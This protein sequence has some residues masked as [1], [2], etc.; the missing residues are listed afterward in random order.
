MPII[1]ICHI[2]RNKT[3]GA[4]SK[5]YLPV[6]AQTSSLI[7]EVP[8]KLKQT[9]ILLLAL[10][11]SAPVHADSEP[12]V[13]PIQSGNETVRYVR[14]VP[15]LEL[16]QSKGIVRVTPLPMDHGSLSFTVAVYNN[17]ENPANFGIENVSP[18]F[19]SRLVTVFTKD[20]LVRRAKN[21]AFWSQFGL[22]LVGG[23]AAGL[24]ASQQDVYSSRWITPRG[25]YQNIFTAPSV[26][27]QWQAMEITDVTV[28]GM[29]MVQTQLDRTIVALG[30]ETV[31]LTTVDPGESYAGRIV[32]DKVRPRG[33]PAPITVKVAWNGEVYPFTFQIA[34]PGTPAPPFTALTR[35][36]KGPDFIPRM[37]P[38]I[39]RPA[40]ETAAKPVS[41][42]ANAGFGNKHVMC[43][44]CR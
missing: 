12:L 37:A 7:R 31:Q 26:A 3:D 33:L 15:T 38:P 17:D 13:Q 8:V 16:A 19:D 39:V 27:G 44:T 14:G 2:E 11:A 10:A 28:A 20:E 43:E 1:R 32:I 30:D 6:R 42:D 5:R 23:V 22:A 9:I 41:A 18:L 34:K 4:P 35:R 25:T 29:M 40:E 24:A 21:R 36:N